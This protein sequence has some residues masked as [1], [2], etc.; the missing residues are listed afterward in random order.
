MST[1]QLA[2]G[3]KAS[4]LDKT[5]LHTVC[6]SG[7]SRAILASAGFLYALHK[8][9]YADARTIGGVSGGSIPT[10]MHAAGMSPGRMVQLAIDIDFNSLLTRRANAVQMFLAFFL[11]ER[12]ARTRPRYGVLG[13]EKLEKF[14]NDLVPEW[15]E[16]YWT[17][18]VAGR[19]QIVF[20]SKG[21]FQYLHDG[22]SRQLSDEAAPLGLAVCA[23]CAVPGIIE[24]KVWNDIYLFDG[25]LSWDG[26][27][28]VGVVARSFDVKASQILACD[29][30]V[31][32]GSKSDFILDF[33][34]LLCGKNCLCPH[35]EMDPAVWAEQGTILVSPTVNK[36]KSLQFSLSVEQKW[37][38]VMSGFAETVVVLWKRGLISNERF[39]ELGRLASNRDLF[40]MD[41]RLD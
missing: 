25:A 16:N 32:R 28:P 14:V 17:M 7:G 37:Y 23:S 41:C 19:T 38:A 2:V 12:L 9:G 30:G 31:S 35:D 36:F 6:G 21:V 20:T 1:T 34:R 10:L 5:Q 39:Q 22:S 15:P 4:A 27:C 8:T 26:Q 29:V 33:W 11:K 18:A 13:S 24:P 3:R 40:I